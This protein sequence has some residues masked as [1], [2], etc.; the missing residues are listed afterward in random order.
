VGRLGLEIQSRFFQARQA[1][2]HFVDGR[3]AKNL[4][5]SRNKYVAANEFHLSAVKAKLDE[6]SSEILESSD[7]AILQL[8]DETE[9]LR[10]LVDEYENT[11]QILLTDLEESSTAGTE[12]SRY[13]T[14]T[15]LQNIADSMPDEEYRTL[16]LEMNVSEQEFFNTGFQEDADN[17]HLLAS[18][19]KELIGETPA[20]V[21]NNTG[22]TSESMLE[23]VDTHTAAFADLALI[24]RQVALSNTQFEEVSTDIANLA[25]LISRSGTTTLEDAQTRPETPLANSTRA[26]IVIGVAIFIIGVL[27]AFILAWQILVPFDSITRAAQKIGGGDFDQS[28]TVSGRGEFASLANTF[29]RMAAQLRTRF[30]SLEQLLTARTHELAVSFE[31]SRRLST[32][33]N[34]KRLTLE[35]AELVRSSFDYYHAQIYLFDDSGKELIMVGGTGEAGKELLESGHSLASGQGLV[36]KAASTGKVVLVSDVAQDP[37]WVS[38]T[39]LPGTKSEIAAPIVLGNRVIGVLDVQHDIPDGLAQSDANLLQ[40]VANQVAVALQNAQLFEEVQDAADHQALVNTINQKIQRTNDIDGALQVA[41]YELGKALQA[42]R[43]AV[44][45]NLRSQPS[46]GQQ[47]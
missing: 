32:I 45:L 18:R 16:I 44:E 5:E 1:E 17:V 43:T 15:N 36:G 30:A 10:T 41:A 20:G 21:W 27:T 29:N 11:F 35:V 14:L 34:R 23:L 28:V 7:E 9:Q 13:E 38:N 26:T 46:N 22:E 6:L 2:R 19:L 4:E 3:N 25:G 33:L 39:L 12:E 31:I 42:S 47:P 24:E 40:S 8:S 37:N